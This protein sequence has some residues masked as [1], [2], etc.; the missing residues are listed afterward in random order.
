MTFRGVVSHQILHPH[1]FG[2]LHGSFQFIAGLEIDFH[3]A[4]SLRGEFLFAVPYDAEDTQSYGGTGYLT[5]AAAAAT[6]VKD[7]K[8]TSDESDDEFFGP[9]GINN[10]WAGIRVP[11]PYVQTYFKPSAFDFEA[12]TYT[13]ADK[14]GQMFYIKG[15][16][17]SMQDEL[18]VFLS[19]WSCLK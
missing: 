15:R 16:K 18:Y 17:E 14:R 11:D 4:D 3:V 1:E 2:L 19:G 5:F 8:G 13:I 6:D 7:D 9:T 10:G 12:G